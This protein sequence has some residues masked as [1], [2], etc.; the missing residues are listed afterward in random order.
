MIDEEI[1]MKKGYVA[2]GLALI[3]LAG[4]TSA[5]AHGSI[6]F[7][8]TL[9]APIYYGGPPVV[10][11]PPPV[12]YSEPPVVYYEP[13]PVYS[14]PNGYIRY[15]EEPRYRHDYGHRRG[16]HRHGHHHDDDDDD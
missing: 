3:A 15:Y 13:A 14:V 11:A 12:Y 5:E 8:I 7:S 2:L 10:Y 6:G 16:G 4:T 1:A 9:G